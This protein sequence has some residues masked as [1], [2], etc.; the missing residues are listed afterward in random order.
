MEGFT[1]S[2]VVGLLLASSSVWLVSRI[3]D[4]YTKREKSL[5]TY[6]QKGQEELGLLKTPHKNPNKYEGAIR[7][8]LLETS[9]RVFL[10]EEPL[11]FSRNPQAG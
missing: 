10:P 4:R 6:L 11:C 9:S 7:L 2:L 1:L 3:H 5:S 8:L